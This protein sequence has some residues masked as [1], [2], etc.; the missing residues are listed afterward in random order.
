MKKKLSVFGC[1]LFI[2]MASTCF[3]LLTDL[4]AG[5]KGNEQEGKLFNPKGTLGIS[6]L[7]QN[8]KYKTEIVELTTD[9]GQN[10]FVNYR[11]KREQFRTEAKAMLK[12]LL[13]SDNE[14]TRME[15]QTEWLALCKR[16]LAEGEIENILKMRGFKDVVSEVNNNTAIVTVLA[17]DLKPNEIWQIKYTVAN[18]LGF[19]VE[20]I[21]VHTRG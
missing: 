7:G 14:K 20:N 4:R 16:I 11:I 9:T 6:D 17:A 21:A 3:G 12:P 5:P 2:F 13:N 10:Y 15:A 19:S 8:I 18:V 1:L